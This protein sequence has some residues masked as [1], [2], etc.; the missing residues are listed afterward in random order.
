MKKPKKNRKYE[1]EGYIFN[2][3]KELKNY[4]YFNTSINEKVI[5]RIIEQ[6]EII[7]EYKFTKRERRL[8]CINI[9]DKEKKDIEEWNKR[10][11]KL[12]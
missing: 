9:Y 2:T 11:L 7:K 10:Q 3:F 8:I 12:F 6:D 1:F 4:I 5:G